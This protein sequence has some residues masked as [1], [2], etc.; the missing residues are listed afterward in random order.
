MKKE[1]SEEIL[2]EIAEKFPEVEVKIHAPRRLYLRTPREE[3]YNLAEYMF[4]QKSFRF[5]IATGIDTREGIEII[6]HFTYD[7]SGTYY[8]IKTLIPKDDCQIKSLT[9]F[10]PAANWIE[11]EM[12]ELLG[13]DFIGH[14]NL[15]PLLMADDWPADLHPLRRDYANEHEKLKLK[16][17]M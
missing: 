13:V 15:I 12:H 6:Y 17:K 14:P 8:N 5:S 2:Q 9:T 10:L 4:K 3:V 11:R 7:E 16:K 1:Y